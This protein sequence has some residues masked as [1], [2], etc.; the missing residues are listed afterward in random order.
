MTES[1][2]TYQKL[3]HEYIDAQAKRDRQIRRL[4]EALRLLLLALQ[5]NDEA[6]NVVQEFPELNDAFKAVKETHPGNV[7]EESP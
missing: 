2:R 5:T 4:R 7:G 1:V 3:L 6:W